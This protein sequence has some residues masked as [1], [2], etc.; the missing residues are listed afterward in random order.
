MDYIKFFNPAVSSNFNLK[1]NKYKDK[2][3]E[4]LQ[5][6]AYNGDASEWLLDNVLTH[7]DSKLFDVDIWEKRSRWSGLSENIYD[8]KISKYNNVVKYKGTSDSFFK[9]HTNLFDF[10]Y[11]DGEFGNKQTYRD[12]INAIARLKDNGIMIVDD[13][14][15]NDKSPAA[16]YK[17]IT[18]F[19]D[20]NKAKI[21]VEVLP[22]QVCIKHLN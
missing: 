21:S 12:C 19:I 2:P 6:G 15:W 18:I 1:L 14:L 20:E 17:D 8:L 10:I 22:N 16:R 11:I 5:I 4:F 3:V 13:Y 7:S 9:T